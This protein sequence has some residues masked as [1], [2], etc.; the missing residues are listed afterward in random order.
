MVQYGKS[1]LSVGLWQRAGGVRTLLQPAR[2]QC[3]R[4]S[5]HFFINSSNLLH[6]RHVSMVQSMVSNEVYMIIL[7]VS[8]RQPALSD[9][10]WSSYHDFYVQIIQSVLQ[11]KQTVWLQ[12]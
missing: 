11:E 6:L 12:S 10:G 2:V 9:N 3:L 5:E 1:I 8:F 4:L 7:W